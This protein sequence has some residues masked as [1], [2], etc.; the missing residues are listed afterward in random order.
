[1]FKETRFI[2]L[3][4][5]QLKLQVSTSFELTGTMLCVNS[6]ID[7]L[8]IFRP[9]LNCINR[10]FT[11]FFSLL[12]L[13]SP[14]LKRL[15]LWVILTFTLTMWTK[16]FQLCCSTLFKSFGWCQHAKGPTH[17][18]GHTLDLILLRV[19]DNLISSCNFGGIF[20]DHLAIEVLVRAHRPVRSRKIIT[21]RS[22]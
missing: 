20:S 6:S 4:R 11:E 3:I 17:T 21:F 14:L 19:T 2:P 10:F 8:V 18:E 12:E 1:L 9:P 5:K 13:D 7:L 15:C 16:T 22:I